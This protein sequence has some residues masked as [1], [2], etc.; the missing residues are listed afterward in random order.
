MTIP[1]V[2]VGIDLVKIAEVAESLEHLGD[3]Y[4]KRIFTEEE[5]AF[6]STHP[7]LAPSRYA[8]RFAAKEATLKALRMED[9]GLDLRS[10]EVVRT[11]GGATDLAL[12]GSA[13]EH[14][15]KAG[16]TS[17]AVSL[18]HEGDYAIAIV[19]AQVGGAQ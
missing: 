11:P 5:I 3:A 10:I 12:H 7:P 2:R 4:A 15:K 6:C 1:S 8:A 17:S 16:W 18:S 9:Q 14:A 13:A 19:V